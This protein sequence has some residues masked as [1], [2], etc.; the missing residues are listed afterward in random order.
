MSPR[1][2]PS[3][4]TLANINPQ[5]STD[6]FDPVIE[7]VDRAADKRY[8]DSLAK[9]RGD[10]Y[11]LEGPHSYFRDLAALS[12]AQVQMQGTFAEPRYAS[13]PAPPKVAKGLNWPTVEEA[14][15]RLARSAKEQRDLTANTGSVPDL[16][17]PS[18]PG[19]LA[20]IFGKAAR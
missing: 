18:M 2:I 13:L 17:R 6:R 11:A 9:A 20:E 4:P 3:E 12:E 10:V 16:L 14:R 5:P 7:A 1:L 8:L 15:E 19:A